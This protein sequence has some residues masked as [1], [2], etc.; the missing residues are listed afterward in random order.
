MTLDCRTLHWTRPHLFIAHL[1]HEDTISDQLT[2]YQRLKRN[3]LDSM[4]GLIVFVL[5]LGICESTFGSAQKEDFEPKSVVC[6][7]SSWAIYRHG[8]GNFTASDIDANLCTHVIY[9]FAELDATTFTIKS[10]DPWADLS[11]AEG[12]HYDLYGETVKL[13]QQNPELKV[14]LAVGGWNAGSE[15]FSNM[16][17]TEDS[18]SS[19]IQS[20]VAFLR[21]YEFDGLDIDWE[22]PGSAGSDNGGRPEDKQN[23]VL[24]IQ[25]FKEVSLLEFSLFNL[26]YL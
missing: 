15:V 23:F 17:Q 10:K 26:K 6:Y 20:S 14:L 25:E 2:F 21:K 12:G 4:K 5:L 7:Y 9:A 8:D 3:Q 16:A 18:R 19:F 1:L 11:P 13:K 22:Y 24:L